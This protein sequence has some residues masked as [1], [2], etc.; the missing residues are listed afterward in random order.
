MGPWLCLA[1][2]DSIVGVKQQAQE[3]VDRA[4]RG[5]PEAITE[6]LERYLPMIGAYLRLKAGRKILA[7]ESVSDLV[8][9]VCRDVL[10]DL[11]GFEYRGEA[12]FRSWLIRHAWSKLCT[13]WKYWK[14]DKRDISR[15]R[16]QGASNDPGIDEQAAS[17]LTPSR[18]A[19]AREE[20]HRFE[21]ALD[22]LPAPMKEAILLRRVAEL[23]Y[24]EIA[25]AMDRSEGAVRNLV[26][27]G[28]AKIALDGES[29][30]GSSK[31]RAPGA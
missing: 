1:C 5:D 24:P 18:E 21:M 6:L 31:K 29:P 12:Q 10:E 30:A 9:S 11:P 20:L 3:L 4:S 8:Q 17:F 2:R 23:P 28:L 13:R 16:G 7:Q 25:Q 22:E 19:V 27:R 26:Y 15:E 14:R